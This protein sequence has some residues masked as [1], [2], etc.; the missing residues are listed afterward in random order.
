MKLILWKKMK[1]RLNVI[2]NFILPERDETH[3]KDNLVKLMSENKIL[4]KR[5][6]YLEKGLY[7]KARKK[8]NEFLK[9]IKGR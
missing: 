5:V 2:E 1:T 3:V 7:N 8:V 9:K 4:E 6:I